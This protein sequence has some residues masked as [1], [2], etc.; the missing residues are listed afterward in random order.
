MLGAEGKGDVDSSSGAPSVDW[1]AGILEKLRQVVGSVAEGSASS[2]DRGP[3]ESKGG[4]RGTPPPVQSEKSRSPKRSG[5]AFSKALGPSASTIIRDLDADE[6]PAK[7]GKHSGLVLPGVALYDC[8]IP[9][10]E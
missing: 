2:C 1:Q 3:V 8:Q 9:S 4:V 5:S 7:C 6:P 10:L